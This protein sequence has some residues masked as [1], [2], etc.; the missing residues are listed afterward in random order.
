M[1]VNR[2]M[3]IDHVA[4]RARSIDFAA[5]GLLLPNPD[6]ILK[7]QGKDVSVYRSMLS[8]A[9]VGGCVRRRKA[10]VRGMDCGLERGAG[11][12]RITKA[13]QQMLDALDVPAIMGQMMDAALY[14]YAPLEVMWQDRGGLLMPQSVVGKPPEWFVFDPENQFRFR[15]R[16]QPLEG[17]LLPERKFLLVRQDATYQNPYGFPDLSMCFWPLVFKKGGLKFWLA[18]T[19]KFGSAFSVGKLPRNSSSEERASLLNALEALIQDGVATIPD[20][21]SVELIEMAGKAASADLYERL[22]LHCRSEISIALLGQNQ[23]TESSANRASAQAGLEVTRDLRDSD[24]R[25][26]ASAFNTLLRWFCELNFSSADQAPVFNIWDQQS[27]DELQASRDH[28]NYE[29]G[30]RFT[31]DYWMRAY[32]YQEGD[33][34]VAGNVQVSAT[35]VPNLPG[36]TPAFA[37]PLAS[38][39]LPS[40]VQDIEDT[41]VQVTQRPWTQVVA[42]IQAEV[43]RSASLPELQR[44]LVLQYAAL[45]TAELEKLMTAAFALA[46]LRGLAGMDQAPPALDQN[47]ALKFAESLQGQSRT[48]EQ[49]STGLQQLQGD[50]AA[51]GAREPVVVNNIIHPS[52]V[53]VSVTNTVQVPEQAAPV[54]HMA[55]PQITVQPAD[56]VVNNT[57]PSVAVQEVERDPESADIVRTRTTYTI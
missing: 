13:A 33:L 18:F 46:Q 48:L 28:S 8:D 11:S 10:A 42:Q 19:E 6:P 53:P 55:A 24:A 49:L 35:A 52:E 17:E 36:G 27:Q 9:L 32:G 4:T 26:V 39:Q 34:Q 43:D 29:A 57:H 30:A 31:N 50:V 1:M 56:V 16:A 54:V 41:L 45:D 15:T 37:D 7:S 51:L 20:D 47:D 5:L 44:S 23:S 21:G 3:L 2:S 25:M 14:G 38:A 12:A 22:V 40:P